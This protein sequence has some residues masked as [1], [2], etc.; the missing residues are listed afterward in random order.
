MLRI[1]VCDDVSEYRQELTGCIKSWSEKSDIPVRVSQF[2]SGEEVLFALESEGDFDAVFMDA[3]LGGMNGM[4]TAVRLR[5]RDSPASIVFVSQYER[6]I[7]E[8]YAV[9]PSQYIAK[10]VTEQKVAVAMD[11]VRMEYEQDE[12]FPIRHNRVI[13]NLSLKKVLYFASDRRRVRAVLEGGGE[14]I[15]YEKLDEVEKRI[16]AGNIHFLRIH[17]SFLV[18]ERRIARFFAGQVEMQNGQRLSISRDKRG[19]VRRYCMNFL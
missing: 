4:E 2:A 11:K 8:M 6:Y 16:S 17:K 12:I 7:K 13:S 19:M 3:S 18:N 14:Q 5:R 15:F 10:P 9:Y 1:A